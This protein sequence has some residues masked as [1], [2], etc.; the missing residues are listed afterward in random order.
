MNA[1]MYAKAGRV[2]ILI[3]R[4]RDGNGIVQ[5]MIVRQRTVPKVRRVSH[6]HEAGVATA[7]TDFRMG[8]ERLV[9]PHSSHV[10]GQDMRGWDVHARY[11]PTDNCDAPTHIRHAPTG[12][13]RTLSTRATR[14]RTTTAYRRRLVRFSVSLVVV[15]SENR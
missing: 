7:L 2:G 4:I 11:A 14:P 10:V 1:G 15:F 9:W 12:I 13:P 8:E 5:E 6:G 3:P